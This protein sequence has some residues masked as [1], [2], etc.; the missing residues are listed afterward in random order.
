VKA[1]IISCLLFFSVKS[2]HAGVWTTG[3][4]QGIYGNRTYKVYV[5]DNLPSSSKPAVIVMLHGCEQNADDFAKGTRIEK[6]ADKEHFIALFPEQ[7][8]A[9][10]SYKCWNWIV[11]GYNSRIGES[12]AIIE[13]LNAVLLQFN[14]DSERVFVT[15]MSAGGSMASIMA[16]CYPERFKAVASHDGSQFYSS[17]VGVDFAEVVKSGATVP[18]SVAANLANSCSQFIYNRP[19]KMPAIIFNGMS[20]PIMT[21]LHAFQ[22]ESEFMAYNDILDNGINDNSYFLEKDIQNIAAGKLYGYT[23]YKT[24]DT[25]HEVL[26]ER[27]MINGL[28]HGWSGGL[29]TLPFND[30][31]GPDASML[32]INF[33]KRFGL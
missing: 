19:K 5:P 18:A 28:G 10:N 8:K 29:A 2:L 27:Y 4:N 1:I 31:N 25:D 17:Y 11:P 9:N 14:A 26:I 12:Q 21:P 30:P 24:I 6:W 3:T 22:V 15:G 20:S 32:I 16:N 23:V 33:F 13:M 7:N